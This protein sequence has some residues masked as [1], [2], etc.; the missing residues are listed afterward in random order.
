MCEEIFFDKNKVY[1]ETD[2]LTA[3]QW[4]ENY[5]QRLK[6]H[7]IANGYYSPNKPVDLSQLEER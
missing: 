1:S 4:I 5:K 7:C 3:G 2:G 6:E